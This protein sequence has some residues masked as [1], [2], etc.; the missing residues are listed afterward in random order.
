MRIALRVNFRRGFPLS[1]TTRRHLASHSVAGDLCKV[2]VGQRGGMSALA[3][4]GPLGS[5]RSTLPDRFKCAR[6]LIGR[7]E[8]GT[9]PAAASVKISVRRLRS[10]LKP[11]GSSWSMAF[12]RFRLTREVM[13]GTTLAACMPSELWLRLS[14]SKQGRPCST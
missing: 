14:C 6:L 13:K 12:V 2:V 8:S 4:T 3:C 5:E 1:C 9:V 10:M 11:R 7:M